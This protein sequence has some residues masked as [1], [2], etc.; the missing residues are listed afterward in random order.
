MASVSK[1]QV[2]DIE[3]NISKS[4]KRQST[5]HSIYTTTLCVPATATTGSGVQLV[6]AIS[7]GSLLVFGVV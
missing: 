6:K 1:K 2:V 4:H 3:K 5:V 7:T